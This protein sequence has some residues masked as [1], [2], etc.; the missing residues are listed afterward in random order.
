MACVA[1]KRSVWKKMSVAC[2]A[3]KLV[4]IQGGDTTHTVPRARLKTNKWLESV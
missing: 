4:W 3:E 2:V 1:E